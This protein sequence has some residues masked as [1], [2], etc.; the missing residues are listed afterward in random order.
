MKKKPCIKRGLIASSMIATIIIAAPGIGMAQ[1]EAVESAASADNPDRSGTSASLQRW[2]NKNVDNHPA[3]LAAQSAVDSARFQLI[4]ADKALYNPELEIDA[5]TAET[6]SASIGISQTIDW[7][8]T[9]GA[10]TS[11]A[12]SRRTAARFAFEATRRGIAAEFLS[13]LSDYHTSSALRALAVRGNTL[14]QRSARLAKDRFDAGDLG[15]VEVDLANLSY[16]QARFKLA[17]AISRQARAT[18][19]LIALTGQADTNWPELLSVFPDPK[20]QPQEIDSTVQQLPQMREITSRVKA[21]QANVKVQSGQGSANPTIAFRAGREEQDNLFG[22]TLSIPLQVR[23]NFRAEVDA[24]NAEMIQAER[25]S[26][27]AYRKLKSRLE[28]AVVSYALSREAWLSWQQ[29]GADTLNEQI[30][31]LERLWKAGELNTTDYLIQ[32][33]QALE[34]KA[35][36]IEQRGRMW[37]DWSEWLIASGKIEHWLYSTSANNTRTK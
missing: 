26:M 17:D 14:M 20:S 18:Q 13:G 31:L 30:T 16:A 19:S 28:I 27:D 8:D 32:L 2:L 12:G 33:T 7:G 37:T 1:A 36:A 35:S 15:K 6:D 23:N 24:A 34:T 5:E 10:R 29:S 22:L 11:M 3:V 4:A 9:R 21:A 25:E